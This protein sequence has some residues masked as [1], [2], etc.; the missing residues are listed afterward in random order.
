MIGAMQS[1]KRPSPVLAP[2]CT[3]PAC[4]QAALIAA[5]ARQSLICVLDLG[6]NGTTAGIELVS[7]RE[8]LATSKMLLEGAGSKSKATGCSIKRAERRR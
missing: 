8:L 2:P 4:S 3:N 6:E 1:T 7:C 5:Q